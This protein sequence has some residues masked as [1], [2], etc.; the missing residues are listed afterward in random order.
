MKFFFLQLTIQVDV[1]NTAIQNI[2]LEKLPVAISKPKV[3]HDI[4]KIFLYYY[5]RIMNL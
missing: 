2:L 3:L 1:L 4:E 5:L